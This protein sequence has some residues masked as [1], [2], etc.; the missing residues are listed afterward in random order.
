MCESPERAI[1]SSCF[2]NDAEAF[3][4]AVP[5]FFCTE[6]E[7]GGTQAV[8]RRTGSPREP[9]SEGPR[10]LVL[11]EGD[12]AHHP[13]RLRLF[14]PVRIEEITA[15]RGA[16]AGIRDAFPADPRLAQDGDV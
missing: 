16:E 11:Q 13:A 14:G 7:H 9:R 4:R 10:V 1:R 3:P 15:A 6:R 8:S 2:A 12:D 5:D